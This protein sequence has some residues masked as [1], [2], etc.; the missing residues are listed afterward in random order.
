MGGC[1]HLRVE[2]L[3]Q[4]ESAQARSNHKLQRSHEVNQVMLSDDIATERHGY[5]RLRITG[6]RKRAL[7]Y[8]TKHTS[9]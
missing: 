4:L 6:S 9:M 3:R 1:E 5:R 8:R 7:L 2:R